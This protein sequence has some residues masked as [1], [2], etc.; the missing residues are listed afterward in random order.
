MHFDVAG[1]FGE[2]FKIP[3]ASPIGASVGAEWR[4]VQSES[5]PD[6]CYSTPDCSLGF[7]STSAVEGEFNVKEFFGEVRVPLIEDRQFIE[8]A[9][10]IA[11]YRWADYSHTGTATAWKLGGEYKPLEDLL[12]RVNYQRAVRAP[13][14][15]EFLNPFTPGLDNSNGDPCAAFNEAV[16]GTTVDQ[17]TR[18]LCV[19]TGAPAGLFIETAPGSGVFTTGVPDVISGQINQFGGGNVN[20]KEEKART[21][22]VGGVY[23]PSWAEGLNITIDWYRVKIK[24]PISS[25][26]ADV[27]LRGCYSA[28]QNPS[29]ETRIRCCARWSTGT[30]STGGLVGNPNFGLDETERNIGF[31]V[32]EGI[33]MQVDYALDLGNFGNVD[34][35]FQATKVLTINDKPTDVSPTNVCKGKYGAICDSPNPSLRFTQRSTWNIG[36]FSVGYRWRYIRA[37]DFE[38]PQLDIEG[39]GIFEADLCLPAF[40]SISDTHYVDFLLAWTPTSVDMLDGFTFQ[41]GLEN[42]FDEDPPIVGAEA[43]TTTQNSGNTFPGTFDTVGRSL[44]LRASKKF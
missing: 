25:L 26:D 34:I 43:G 37:T 31:L 8:S 16:G 30:E 41:V 2:G 17:F 11:A 33:D 1:D 15:F 5:F 27:I 21:L 10:L 23:Q 9:S 32:S 14:I 36:D 4:R 6:D 19:A 22:T 42:A 20:L 12:L 13:N 28:A 3:G 40:C 35:N 38:Q 7:G 44:T 24:D 29:G 18:D 39:D